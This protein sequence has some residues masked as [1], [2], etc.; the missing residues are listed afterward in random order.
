MLALVCSKSKAAGQGLGGGNGGG[1]TPVPIPNTEVKPTSADGTWGEAPWESRALPLNSP[2]DLQ[3]PGGDCVLGLGLEIGADRGSEAATG[4]PP[5]PRFIGAI[6]PG[7]DREEW[8][9]LWRAFEGL[10]PRWVDKALR[11]PGFLV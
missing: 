9:R 1:E 3:G 11:G 8:R 5:R 7:V 4:V 6:A 10:V 2:P